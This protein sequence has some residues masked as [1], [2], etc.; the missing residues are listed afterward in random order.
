MMFRVVEDG[1]AARRSWVAAYGTPTNT[2]SATPTAT[3]SAG[4]IE[5]ELCGSCSP[6]ACSWTSAERMSMR[7]PCASDSHSTTT[8]RTNGR[9]AKRER[10][11]GEVR[12]SR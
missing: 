9:R 1:T 10:C 11:S 3:T 8:P 6:G 4:V 2:T 7:V 5:P 12:V